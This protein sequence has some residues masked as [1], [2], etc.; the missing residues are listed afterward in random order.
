[1]KFTSFSIIIIIIISITIDWRR[2]KS[3]NRESGEDVDDGV[4]LE[5]EGQ[6]VYATLIC[7]KLQTTNNNK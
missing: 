7:E 4:R 3:V 5:Q 6:R 2:K 1:M